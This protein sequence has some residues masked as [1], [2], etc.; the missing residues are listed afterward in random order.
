VRDGLHDAQIGSQIVTLQSRVAVAEVG[1]GELVD[2]EL[3]GQKAPAERRIRHETDAQLPHCGKDAVGLDAALEQRV[4]TLYRRN[5]MHR[6]RPADGRG[7]GLRQA[8]VAD[9]AL[10]HEISECPDRVLD[11]NPRVDPVQVEQVDV[12][13]AEPLQGAFDRGGHVLRTTVHHRPAVDERKRALRREPETHLGRDRHRVP[14]AGQRA[15]DQR[16]VVMRSVD[17]SGIE[18][19]HAKLDCPT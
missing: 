9:L 13:G 16:L 18:Q 15:A 17:L 7:R 3:P 11:R 12:L 2:I 8:Q 6:M 4:L 1:G 5:R 10:M 14:H 19:P